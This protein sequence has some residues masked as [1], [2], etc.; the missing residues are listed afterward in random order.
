M[1]LSVQGPRKPITRYCIS[2]ICALQPILLGV[3]ILHWQAERTLEQ[4]SAQTAQEA[5]R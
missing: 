2:L 1:P 3:L 5:V 4:S